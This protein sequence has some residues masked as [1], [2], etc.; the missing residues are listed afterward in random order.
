MEAV[1]AVVLTVSE[2]RE[3]LIAFYTRVI[4]QDAAIAQ[5]I[6]VGSTT[7]L[8][9]ISIKGFRNIDIVKKFAELCEFDIDDI[10]KKNPGYDYIFVNMGNCQYELI[11]ERG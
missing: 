7:A 8:A 4:M 9:S 1:K 11:S 5:D 10:F 2:V 3:K 6:V